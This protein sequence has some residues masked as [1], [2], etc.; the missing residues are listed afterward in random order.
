MPTLQ[1]IR[2]GCLGVNELG[3]VKIPE[4]SEAGQSRRVLAANACRD[5]PPCWTPG[6]GWPRLVRWSRRGRS[7]ATDRPR[8][9]NAIPWTL[10]C[11]IGGSPQIQGRWW[12]YSG[13]RSRSQAAVVV[14]A[15]AA[16]VAVVVAIDYEGLQLRETF[17]WNLRGLDCWCYPQFAFPRRCSR[18]TRRAGACIQGDHLPLHHR[19]ASVRAITNQF[20]QFEN[21]FLGRLTL[22]EKAVL[23]RSGH[24][25]R[26]LKLPEVE[27][28]RIRPE[29]PILRIPDPIQTPKQ[30]SFRTNPSNWNG[31]KIKI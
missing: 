19:T 20:D 9:L 5:S 7:N 1:K 10:Q 13:S 2:S 24:G 8:R 25:G 30:I 22:I 29:A 4:F 15:A 31:K 12:C 27:C 6:S 21:E 28:V 26:I 18:A 3:D 14:A 23:I 11:W 17:S 16:S